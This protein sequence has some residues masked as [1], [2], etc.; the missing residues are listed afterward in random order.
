LEDRRIGHLENREYRR[1]TFHIDT[2]YDY[3]KEN[4]FNGSQVW[5][6]H[7]DTHQ[8]DLPDLYFE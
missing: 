4:E 1:A 5:M 6:S 8:W 3:V 2:H 7:G